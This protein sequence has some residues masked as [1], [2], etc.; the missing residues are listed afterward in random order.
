LRSTILGAIGVIVGIAEDKQ[1]CGIALGTHQAT[2]TRNA[3]PGRQ[4]LTSDRWIGPMEVGIEAQVIPETSDQVQGGPDF[5][6]TL[7][8]EVSATH[9]DRPLM[10]GPLLVDSWRNPSQRINSPGVKSLSL[11]ASRWDSSIGPTVVVPSRRST[12][13]TSSAV[14]RPSKSGLCVVIT[15]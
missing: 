14:N 3:L 7:D 10:T 2:E 6:M 12:T 8:D 9:R 4:S 15:T 1:G 13:R 11:T 5:T